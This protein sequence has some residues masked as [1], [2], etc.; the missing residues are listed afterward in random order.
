[1]DKRTY[2]AEVDDSGTVIRVI[3]GT[4]EWATEMLGGTWVESPVKVGAGY[5]LW[6]EGLRPPRPYPSWVWD[7]SSW[8]A[9]V[10]YPEDGGVYEWDES[11]PGWVEV[12]QPVEGS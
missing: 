10:S 12:E 1:M 4:A 11:V 9:P 5:V 7:G 6:E 3:V 8:V 2:A